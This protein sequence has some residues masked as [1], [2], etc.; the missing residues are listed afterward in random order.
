MSRGKVQKIKA[1][2]YRQ[3]NIVQIKGAKKAF[4]STFQMPS[5]LGTELKTDGGF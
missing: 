3:L 2:F 4:F 5:S 1:H